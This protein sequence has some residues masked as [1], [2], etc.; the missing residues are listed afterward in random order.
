M[1]LNGTRYRDL[2]DRIKE[3]EEEVG[4]LRERLNR[5]IC[6]YCNQVRGEAHSYINGIESACPK[7]ASFP[8]QTRGLQNEAR[9]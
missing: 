1:S 2:K 5:S 6:P 3:L 7:F 9:Y 8:E 4:S